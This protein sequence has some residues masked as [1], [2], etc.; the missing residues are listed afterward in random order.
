M[1]NFQLLTNS[2]SED[3]GTVLGSTSVH[4]EVIHCELLTTSSFELDISLFIVMMIIFGNIKKQSS[5]IKMTAMCFQG[6]VPEIDKHETNSEPSSELHAWTSSDFGQP[7]SLDED[8][9]WADKGAGQEKPDVFCY[10]YS[11]VELRIPIAPQ[12]PIFLKIVRINKKEEPIN[13]DTDD[14]KKNTASYSIEDQ[15]L[16]LVEHESDTDGV[17]EDISIS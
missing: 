2:L 10:W 8:I 17:G 4:S 11:K 14:K 9:K 3:K 5:F 15:I 13:T 16:S 6:T 1:L 12:E 7:K